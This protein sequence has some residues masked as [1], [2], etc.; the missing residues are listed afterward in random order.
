[1]DILCPTNNPETLIG[2]PTVYEEDYLKWRKP[3]RYCTEVVGVTELQNWV[4]EALFY[5]V[6]IISIIK[7]NKLM[8]ISDHNFHKVFGN[9]PRKFHVILLLWKVLFF[10][11]RKFLILH[12]YDRWRLFNFSHVCRVI[13]IYSEEWKYR[14]FVQL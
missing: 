4:F 10:T 9:W 8:E 1:M 6:N 7:E 12:K 3:Y 11:S 14:N 13:D 5:L 2:W